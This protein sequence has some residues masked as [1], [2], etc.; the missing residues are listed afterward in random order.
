MTL[1]S[2][3]QK[4]RYTLM[5]QCWEMEADMRPKFSCLVTSLSRSLEAMVGYMEVP[6]IGKCSTFM[7]MGSPKDHG[8]DPDDITNGT[9]D[10]TSVV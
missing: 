9:T 1:T 6:S 3:S 8:Y 10:E 4:C 2:F 7:K 5:L